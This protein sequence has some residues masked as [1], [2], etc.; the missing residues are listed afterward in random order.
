[1]ANRFLNV[2][3]IPLPDPVGINNNITLHFVYDERGTPYLATPTINE[4]VDELLLRVGSKQD[5]TVSFTHVLAAPAD[6]QLR[7]AAAISALDYFKGDVSTLRH[8][9]PSEFMSEDGQFKPRR[10]VTIAEVAVFDESS[11]DAEP[12][13]TEIEDIS[14]PF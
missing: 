1:M 11:P 10:V 6:Y 12:T 9:D 14:D 5:V 4:R 8:V 13:D 7:T 2:Y 3:F